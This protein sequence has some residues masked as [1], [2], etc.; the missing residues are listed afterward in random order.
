ML[1]II[2]RVLLTALTLI[3]VERLI[4]GIHVAGVYSAIIAAIFL[5]LVNLIIRPILL[6]LSLPITLLTLGLF[7]FVIN[8]AL[9]WFVASFVD[10]FSVD[11]FLPALIGSIVVSV[12]ST[13]GNKI[14]P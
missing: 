2:T 9:F 3:I 5:G 4:D 1:H 7:S 8:A 10:G 11:G 14:L 13:L 12:V 6:V